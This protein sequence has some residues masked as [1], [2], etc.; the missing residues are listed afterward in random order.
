M[1]RVLVLVCPQCSH[2][3]VILSRPLAHVVGERTRLTVVLRVTKPQPRHFAW[4]V[5]NA[6]YRNAV[7]WGHVGH[8]HTS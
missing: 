2:R 3:S 8:V 1:M 6:P 7:T 4:E 5:K